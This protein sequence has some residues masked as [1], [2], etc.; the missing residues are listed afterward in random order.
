MGDQY[1]NQQPEELEQFLE[2]IEEDLDNVER[3]LR[4]CEESGVDAEFMVHAKSET[5]EESA[6]NT[7]VEPGQIVKTLVFKAGDDFIAVLCPGDKRVSES[8]LEGLTGEDVRMANP[9]E[10]KQHTG[11]VVGGVSPF[12]LEIPV[13]MEETLME[14][15]IVKPAAGSRV[16]GVEL[17]AGELAEAVDAEAADVTE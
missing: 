5:A 4:A 10:V 14:Q 2:F 9:S 6:E 17:E 8:E 3:A 12:D 1:F 15:E 7:D 13:Y 16:V 11:Y